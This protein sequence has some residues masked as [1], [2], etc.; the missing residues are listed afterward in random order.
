MN[1]RQRI[2]LSATVAAA[3]L[4]PTAAVAGAPQDVYLRNSGSSVSQSGSSTVRV[5][6]DAEPTTLMSLSLQLPLRNQSQMDQMIN[7]GV[8]MSPVEYGERFA[9]SQ[10]QLDKVI[11][12]ASAQGLK[13]TAQQRTSGTVRVTATVGQI[14]KTFHVTLKNARLG[15]VNGLAVTGDP[16]VPASLGL[17]GIAGLNTVHRL[18]TGPAAGTTSMA[19]GAQ[20]PSVRP[21][22]VGIL[23]WGGDSQLTSGDQGGSSAAAQAGRATYIANIERPN[24]LMTQCGPSEA[25]REHALAVRSAEA[26]SPKATIVYSG[27]ASCF[28][29]DLTTSLS[30]M[31]AQRRVSTISLPFAATSR[32]GLTAADRD[33]WNRPLKQASLT[34]VR[35]VAAGDLGSSTKH[36]VVRK[37]ASGE[38]WGS[39]SLGR[40]A[41][42]G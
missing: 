7:R 31:V 35:V 21:P 3:V 29:L 11:G 40:F 38:R 8:T 14:N 24:R 18:E 30:A 10:S 33:G 32:A 36:S 28:D 6:G 1:S 25:K 23:L 4:T 15:T 12:W 34:G 39:Q 2:V 13:V 20:R 19:Y 42:A 22:S 37:P 27:A 9:P 17:T 16:A 5:F 41:D 26:R